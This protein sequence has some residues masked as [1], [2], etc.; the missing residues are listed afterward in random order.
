MIFSKVDDQSKEYGNMLEKVNF[1][2]TFVFTFEAMLKL[3]AYKLV[4]SFL[5]ILV[6]TVGTDQHSKL[7]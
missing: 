7:L 5:W 3:M 6:D 2:F 1:V 4:S